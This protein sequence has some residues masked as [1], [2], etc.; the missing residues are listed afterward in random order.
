MCAVADCCKGSETCAAGCSFVSV[1]AVCI[2][3]S[4]AAVVLSCC[5]VCSL[6]YCQGHMIAMTGPERYQRNHVC[7]CQLLAAAWG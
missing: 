6:L 4:Q 1:I 3:Q 7:C 5:V 2:W